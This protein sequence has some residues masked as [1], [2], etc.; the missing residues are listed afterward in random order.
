MC[1]HCL[2]TPFNMTC[3]VV[4]ITQPKLCRRNKRTSSSTTQVTWSLCQRKRSMYVAARRKQELTSIHG[5]AGILRG[6]RG[7]RVPAAP[8]RMSKCGRRIKQWACEFTL[9]HFSLCL[10]KWSYLFSFAIE[11]VIW[12]DVVNNKEGTTMT[13]ITGSLCIGHHCWRSLKELEMGNRE[14]IHRDSKGV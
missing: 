12:I 5:L 2:S 7:H 9:W 3:W 4:S 13:H 8:H 11:V 6:W 1:Q 10:A 14:P